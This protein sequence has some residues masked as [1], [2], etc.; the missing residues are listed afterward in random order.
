MAYRWFL[1]LDIQDSVP[2]FSTFGK[3]DSRRFKGTDIFEQIFYGILAQCIEAH[4]VDTSEIFIDGTHIKAHA[5]NKKYE[6]K[7]IT[8]DTL[9][10]VKSLQK[11]VEID[12]EK[13]LK[14]PLKRKS[15]TNTKVKK[16]SKNDADSVIKENINKSLPMPHK[17]HVIKTD[18]F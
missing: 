2:H 14:K 9:F 3:N 8:E 18:G 4:L 6:S 15:E 5:N 13:Q 7:E 1:G 12:R 10:Y 17:W 11:E 16:I